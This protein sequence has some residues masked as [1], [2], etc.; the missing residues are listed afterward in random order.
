V[1]VAPACETPL[2]RRLAAELERLRAAQLYRRRRQVGGSHGA[3]IV[4]EGRL[5]TNFCS[6]DYLGLAAD[7]R[8]AAAAASALERCGTGSGAAALVSGYN[9]EHARLEE[10]LAD[11]VGRPR[12]LLFSS[13]W[14]ANLG[15]LRALL[16]RNDSLI[17]DELNHASL[18]DGGRLS[19]ARYVRVGHCNL[20]SFERALA[21]AGPPDPEKRKLLVTDAVF[22]MDG[23]LADLPRLA[24]LAQRH[25]AALM[26]DDAHG[27]G[28]LGAH[29][30]GS[31]ELFFSSPEARAPSP[32]V[33]V[34][35]LGKSLGCAGAFVAGS[36]T[37]IEYLI[38]RARTSV[39]STA[40]PPALAAAARAA[41][42]ILQAEPERRE[43]LFENVRHFRHGAEQLGIPLGCPESSV[44]YPQPRVLTPIQPLILGAPERALEFARWLYERGLWVAA[45]RPPTVPAGTARLRITLSAA[46][47]RAQ[48]DRLLEALAEGLKVH[49]GSRF[50]VSAS[51]RSSRSR[52][53]KLAAAH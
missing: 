23:D 1:N 22:S 15:V 2:E 28:V 34:A 9:V 4:V 49:P 36:E 50:P 13:G 44:S 30:R 53:R 52:N 20:E 38:Q 8:L 17:A 26:V 39:F 14:A 33:Y 32:E 18:I 25:E 6:N 41:L 42:R 27:F 51:E 7:P 47:Q 35:T 46:H 21:E 29:G 45:I 5:C 3:Q 24:E 37:L 40:P 10:E 16:G 48:I 11:F 31:L 43:R 12:A 19:G